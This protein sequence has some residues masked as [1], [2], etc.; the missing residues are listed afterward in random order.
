MLKRKIAG[1][2]TVGLFVGA[3]QAADFEYPTAAAEGG[4]AWGKVTYTFNPSAAQLAAEKSTGSYTPG[5]LSGYKTI[6]P[7]QYLFSAPK[8][9]RQHQASADTEVFPR[10][11][12]VQLD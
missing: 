7:A 4:E 10:A 11:M 2:V 3:A 8:S 6:P 1:I 9:E 12:A 5:S